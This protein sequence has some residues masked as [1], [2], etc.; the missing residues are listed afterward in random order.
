MA[1]R[2]I[3]NDNNTIS[4]VLAKNGKE[5]RL[6][7]DIVALGYDKETALKKWALV[8]TPTFKQ[9][10]GQGNVDINGEP[11]I[12]M[13]NQDPV[14]ISDSNSTKHATENL[15]TFTSKKDPSPLL[16]NIKQ[17]FNLVKKDGNVRNIPYLENAMAIAETIEKKYPG[18]R[19]FVL[20]DMGGDYI[21]LDVTPHLDPDNI[22][23]QA[24]ALELAERDEAVDL[25]MTQF[26]RSIGVK[27]KEVSE[28]R[29]SKGN[30]IPVIAKADM[31]NKLVEYAKGKIGVDTLPEEAAHFMV[32]LLQA[33]G[34]PLFDSMM[35][36]IQSFGVY[37]DVIES[38]VY[39]KLYKGDI[40]KLKK[41][42]IGK[43]IAKVIVNKF[44]EESPAN[45]R[46]ATTWWDR[47]ANFIRSI[48]GKVQ[49][50][51]YAEAA[52]MMLNAAVDDHVNVKRGMGNVMGEYYQE[53]PVVK[54]DKVGNT[55]DR[56]NKENENWE[57]KRISLEK[58][59]LKQPWFV[60]EGNEIER[61][62]GKKDGPYAGTH[63]K[64]RVSDA[65]K[66]HFWKINRGKITDLSGKQKQ[67][68]LD[69]NEMRKVTG[70]MG[71]TVM[72]EL[73]ELYANK[74]GNR[75]DILNNSLFTEAQFN[76]LEQGIKDLLAQIRKVQREEVDPKGKVIIRT[77]QM[78]T[79]KDQSIGGSIDLL[80]VFS[81]NSA[82][83]YDYKFVSPSKAAGYVDRITNRIIEDPF[84]VKMT[85]YD[86]QMSQ[87]KQNLEQTYGITKVRQSRIVPIHIR[88]KTAKDGK[89]T[90]QIT[91]VQMGTKYSEFLQQIPVA[92]ELTSFDD[93]NKIIKK[94]LVR[95]AAVD[96]QLQ[97]K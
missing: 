20:Q 22:Y 96:R 71:H 17:R 49:S 65:V 21:K 30:I 32:E 54:K 36:N 59:G 41:E 82:A 64:G 61:Y 55:I 43:L 5:S 67:L 4:K 14:F 15:G 77:E 97:T 90:N 80:A 78:I 28:I 12:V 26:L 24:E 1:C 13:V 6:F 60:E 42:A 87:Y 37:Q 48:F 44:I 23:H 93:I 10:F 73:V 66:K 91:V 18:V 25:A 33:E 74:K 92:G 51:P 85:T 76:V 39:Q 2:I 62:V 31:V 89:L 79:N 19:A 81:D 35:N 45:I 46:R 27:L 11:R 53:L 83:I 57:T 63:I 72:E 16:N 47:L 75:R 52:Q 94:L 40:N 7:K 58:A 95:K 69:N 88:Y 3:R 8:Y 70:S 34:S 84:N 9:W 86:L 50:D 38:D 56:L 68:R 29:D